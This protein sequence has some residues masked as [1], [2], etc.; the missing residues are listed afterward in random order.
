MT[1]LL[2]E[3]RLPYLPFNLKNEHKNMWQQ[4]NNSKPELQGTNCM[5]L[6]IHGTL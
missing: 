2:I 4:Y 3:W 6:V 1:T 5:L